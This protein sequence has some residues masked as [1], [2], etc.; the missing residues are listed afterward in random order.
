MDEDLGEE[1]AEG[2]HLRQRVDDGSDLMSES[3]SFGGS[4]RRGS[5]GWDQ[6]EA[7]DEAEDD[8][9]EFHA[10]DKIMAVRKARDGIE[11]LIHW[12]GCDREGKPWDDTWEPASNIA[13]VWRGTLSGPGGRALNR[14]PQRVSTSQAL[15]NPCITACSLRWYIML[16]RNVQNCFPN[17]H[18]DRYTDHV[19]T[20]T[21]CAAPR[22][23]WQHAMCARRVRDSFF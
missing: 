10:V 19:P 8:A 18:R 4:S 11:Y 1:E 22:I 17:P 5:T 9:D 13:G 14:K 15:P 23:R 2:E 20:S 21:K 16:L 7:A 12:E 3:G 6:E